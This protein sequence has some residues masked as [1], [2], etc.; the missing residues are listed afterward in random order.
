MCDVPQIRTARLLLR[1][2]CADDHAAAVRLWQR[3]EVY[4]FITGKPLNEQEVWMRL[5]RYGG[6]WDFLGFGYWAVEELSTQRYVGQLGFADFRRGLVGFDGRYPEAGW[7]L[8]PDFV[9]LGYAAEA[10]EAA[11]RWLD[12]ESQWSKSFCIIGHDNSK[13]LRLASALGY[14]FVLNTWFGKEE[15]GVFFRDKNM[16]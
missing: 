11:C 9:G 5:L 13:S 3:E 6:L 14:R 2:H 10:M 4:G 15:T 16:P 7:V 8:H 12:H 1:A